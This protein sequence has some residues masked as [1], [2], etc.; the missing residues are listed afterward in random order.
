MDYKNYHISILDDVDENEPE[1]LLCKIYPK[2]DLKFEFLIDY[3]W[4]NK[5]ELQQNDDIT[6]WVKKYI[7]NHE[8]ILNKGDGMI[9]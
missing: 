3:F 8:T 2:D 7:N 1:A 9:W 4:I 6:F 5:K